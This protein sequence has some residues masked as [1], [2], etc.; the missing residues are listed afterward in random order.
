M[1]PKSWRG[2]ASSIIFIC[3]VHRNY[4]ARMEELS[5]TNGDLVKHSQF[6]EQEQM[7]MKENV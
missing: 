7:L 1:V 2:D 5:S 3:K 6:L 4:H